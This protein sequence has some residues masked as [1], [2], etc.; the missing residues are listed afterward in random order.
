MPAYTKEELDII[1]D[2]LS[3]SEP[4][5]LTPFTEAQT[6]IP[7]D[8]LLSEIA[9]MKFVPTFNQKPINSNFWCVL[10]LLIINQLNKDSSATANE[11][12]LLI[13]ETFPAM[14]DSEMDGNDGGL[15]KE[16][17]LYCLTNFR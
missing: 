17:S 6:Y 7:T 16:S 5:T 3:R 10:F 12:P 9:Q 14:I 13:T 8:E 11:T 1:L 4:P 2:S 15:F